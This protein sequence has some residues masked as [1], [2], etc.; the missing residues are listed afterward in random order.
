ME[1]SNVEVL[2]A[3]KRDKYQLRLHEDSVISLKFATSGKWFVSTGT[4]NLLNGWQTPY[5]A[6]I[7]RV[8]FSFHFSLFLS[9]SL[10][11]KHFF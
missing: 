8:I 1:N 9:P 4:D 7:F 6:S 11:E 2:H 5:G 10:T 3:T